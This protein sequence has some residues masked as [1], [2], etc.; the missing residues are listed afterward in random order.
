[1][2]HESLFPTIGSKVRLVD[3]VV[4]E[5][6]KLILNGQL[7]P[8]M[9]LP[10][11]RELA[12]EIGVSRPVVREAVSILVAKGLLETKRGVGTIVRNMTR[13]QIVEP[14]NLLMKIRVGGG[15]TFEQLY[16]VRSIL[17]VKNA[18]LAASEAT[19][20]DIIALR[21][22]MADMEANQDDM[23][24][25]AVKDTDFHQ[26]LAHATHNP[27]LELLTGVIRDLLEEYIVRVTVYLD[28]SRDVLPFHQRILDA[29]A[30]KDVE[31]ARQA[32]EAHLKQIKKNH[33]EA[34]RFEAMAKDS[35]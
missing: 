8:G 15:V 12:D 11:E 26:L 20:D 34:M 35:E 5:I 2:T 28:P 25:F 7:K 22:V 29:V 3:R 21:Q 14:F 1:M 4:D 27:V 32:M 9:K 18:E 19:D 10:P 31:G 6:Q 17:E 33:E 13:D 30:A 16:Q 23:V 24:V